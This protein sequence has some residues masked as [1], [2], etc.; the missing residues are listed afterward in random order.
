MIGLEEGGEEKP[1]FFLY[2][3][4]L[5]VCL[6]GFLFGYD[7]GIISG[8]LGPLEK[9]FLLSTPQKEW[10]V[11]G[12]TLGAIVG[13]LFAGPPLVLLASLIF[14]L[15]STLL[16]LAGSFMAL[17]IGRWIVGLGVG[18]ASMITPV[19]IGEVAPK[20]VRG[21]LSTLN[22]FVVTLG[23]VT[24]YG[25]NL[26]FV[27]REEGWRYMFGLGA[28]PALI[29]LSVM[30]TMP[31][32]P[33]HQVVMG[34]MTSAHATLR[35]VYGTRVSDE[36]L[37]QEIE[38]IRED[39]MYASSGSYGDFLKPSYGQPLLIACLLQAAQQLSGF[40]TVMYYAATILTMADFQDPTTLALLVA[41]AN[42]VFTVMAIY[43][44]DRQGRRW[45]LILT[46]L[47]MI[48]SLGLL[49]LCFQ[50][51]TG[52]H[53]WLLFALVA[54]VA[55]Y[56]LGLGYIPWVVQ[57][58]LFPLPLRGKANGI[59]T[60]TNW[61]F[62]F[63]VASTF[64]SMTQWLSPSGTFWFY[65]LVSALLWVLITRFLPETANKSLEEIGSLFHQTTDF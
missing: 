40:N 18:I 21:R 10:I 30:P 5:S 49:G 42:M 27:S 38:A 28:L 47:T 16:A 63:L 37:D 14:I 32:S 4:V 34:K 45:I 44:I 7:T 48:L 36:L 55:S 57:A 31:E 58:E 61:L 59:A 39:S 65:A 17:V 11:A 8:A 22:T 25:V 15:G 26:A 6:G 60:A 41:L 19:Y 1:T 53:G 2:M 64:L 13:G 35:R 3:L 56:A 46:M 51:D 12:T 23:Q 52:S 9:D 33:R 62:N 50:R 24:A 20:H 29:Q 54:Y 43:W